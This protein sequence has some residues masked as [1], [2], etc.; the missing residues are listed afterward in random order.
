MKR[1]MKL[2]LF[3]DY[4]KLQSALIKQTLVRCF[5][6]WLETNTDMLTFSHDLFECKYTKNTNKDLLGKLGIYNRYRLSVVIIYSNNLTWQLF[7]YI[8]K[9]NY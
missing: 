3:I 2:K 5:L 7:A 4:E 8:S 9:L 1:G 6:D